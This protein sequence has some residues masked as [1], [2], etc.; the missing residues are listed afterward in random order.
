MRRLKTVNH[1]TDE[2]LRQKLKEE[3][4]I[5]QFKIWQCIYLVQT[6]SV[7]TADQVG[8]QIGIS[9]FKVYRHIED[10][11]K[12]GP[13]GVILQ[14]RGGRRRFYLT[15]EEESELL[16]TISEKA[17]SGLILTS[18]DIRK[19]VENKIGHDVSD[20]YLWDLFHRYNWKKK[21][22]RPKHPQKN[23]EKQEEFKKNSKKTWQ[24]A[25]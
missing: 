24:P 5:E 17:L 12:F 7:T 1:M 22:P 20:D 13:S 14:S 21:A 16:N 9:K 3:K 25:N 19:E 4:S 18:S 15:L 10:Y 11:N 2:G 23:V 6:Q 8:N